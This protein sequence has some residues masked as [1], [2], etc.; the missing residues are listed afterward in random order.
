MTAPAT[1]IVGASCIFP[2]GPS[3]P[4]ANAAL[5]VQ[6]AL[7]RRHPTWVDRC[8]FP[9]KAIF[10][11]E[12]AFGFDERR[13]C[14]LA[15]LALA[16]LAGS[17]DASGVPR[18]APMP[19][20]LVLPREARGGVPPGLVEA[21]LATAQCGRFDWTQITA[22][23][24]GHAMGV[25]ALRQAADAVNRSDT[26]AVVLAV[27]SWL[28]P[29]ALTSLEEANLLH[30]A[31]SRVGRG[32]RP[33]PYGRVPGEGAAAVVLGPGVRSRASI[34]SPRLTPSSP[35]A[36]LAAATLAEEELP[37]GSTGPCIG[38]GLT[39]AAQE[40]L[41]LSGNAAQLVGRISTDFNG[42]PYRADEFGFTTLR[43]AEALAPGWK[44]TE[45]AMVSGDIGA[46]SAVSQLALAAYRMR[47]RPARHHRESEPPRQLILCSSDDSLRA[48][49]VLDAPDPSAKVDRST[50]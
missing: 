29:D 6:M 20:W 2:S 10:F 4:L 12:P 32:P 48:A 22:L 45:P 49:M 40:A 30:G 44:R 1:A 9:A 41:R 19:L 34:A 42:E 43:L 21:L 46:A 26:L 8:G 36:R 17:L 28:H 33:N 35:W 14:A 7:P 18:G 27:D 24:G 31:H 47:G 25:H 3:L 11:S 23:R 50:T 13:W 15:E 38:M 5:R 37:A 39:H 16:D